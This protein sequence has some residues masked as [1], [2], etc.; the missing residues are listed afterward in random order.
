MHGGKKR[1]KSI[2]SSSNVNDNAISTT[3]QEQNNEVDNLAGDAGRIQAP[4]TMGQALE[5]SWVE[6]NEML[7]EDDIEN[8]TRGEVP[9][10]GGASSFGGLTGNINETTGDPLP[11]SSTKLVGRAFEE[12]MNVIWSWL[13]DDEVSTIGIYRMG[14]VGKMTMLQHIHN[15]LL[16]R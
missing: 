12:N 7:M 1:H 13:L 6:I 8:G 16:K 14:G 10:G 3:P 15:K 5:L 2:A 9:P 4:D 11:T